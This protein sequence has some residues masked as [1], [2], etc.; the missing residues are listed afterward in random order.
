MSERTKSKKVSRRKF[1]IRGGLGTLGVLA[2]GTYVFRN[3][4]RRSI[5]E[6]AETMVPPYSG[7]GTEA[8]LWF[9][10]T[11]E[12]KIIF[13]S[14]KVE[15][16]QGTFTGLA[17]I[18][19][20]ELDVSIE[21]IEVKAAETATGI[22]DGMSTGGSLSIAS[23]W[24]PLREMAATTRE[25]VK[26]EAAKKIGVAASG[27]KTENGMVSSGG[28]TMTYAEA[29]ADVTEWN[30]PDT[31]ELRPIKDYKFVGKP[32]KRV[33]LTAKVVGD[34]IFGMDA[35]MPDMLYATVVRPEHIGANLKS[36]D[37]S[38]AEGM[39]GVVKVIKK[40]NWVG[41]VAKSF[42]EALA[43]KNKIKV[44]WNIPKKWSARNFRKKHETRK[45]RDI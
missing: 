22:V 32:I 23:L 13:H 18:I 38:G 17:Q 2:L 41:V 5:I 39:P 44:E 6:M 40:D 31:P 3:S 27:L 29:V 24:Q 8:N 19:A 20:D 42:P 1:L 36:A 25:F 37:T 7:T 34:P 45:R 43:A 14:P 16:G 21:Q 10:I 12:N 35:E 33:D 4:V 28:K 26:Q 30:I 11:K 15:M 9:E